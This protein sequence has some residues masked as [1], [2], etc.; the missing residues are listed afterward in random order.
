MAVTRAARL[1][2]RQQLQ[3]RASTGW[4]AECTQSCSPAWPRDTVPAEDAACAARRRR[5]PVCTTREMGPPPGVVRRQ[6][7]YRNRFCRSES[8]AAFSQ[9]R[10]SRS[11]V[12]L[13]CGKYAGRMMDE[14][15]WPRGSEQGLSVGV[16]V[17]LVRDRGGGVRGLG[18]AD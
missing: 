16:V 17:L 4:M 15:V 18:R 12:G 9:V 6:I 7:D 14:L 13:F 3:G 8:N 5:H 11:E 10:A 2:P 1:D